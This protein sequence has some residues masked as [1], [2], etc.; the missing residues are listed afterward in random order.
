[1]RE[2]VTSALELVGLLVFAI[3]VGSLLAHALSTPI[4]CVIV[5]GLLIVTSWVIVRMGRERDA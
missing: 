4:A 5:G 2:L 3:G 1:M